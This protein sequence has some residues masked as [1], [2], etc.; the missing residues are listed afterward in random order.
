MS[1]TL[2]LLPGLTSQIVSRRPVPEFLPSS[3]ITPTDLVVTKGRNEHDIVAPID[4]RVGKAVAP[5]GLLLDDM[6]ILVSPSRWL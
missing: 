6:V 1:D 2:T 5:C 3:R 4:H